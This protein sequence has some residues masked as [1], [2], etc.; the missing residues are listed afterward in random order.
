[1][2]LPPV[3]KVIFNLFLKFDGNGLIVIELLKNTEEELQPF[4]FVIVSIVFLILR[5]ELTIHSDDVREDQNTT[6]EHERRE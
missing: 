6:E 4:T 1:M 2:V 5:Q 3:S